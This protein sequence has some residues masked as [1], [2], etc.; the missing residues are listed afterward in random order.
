MYNS[1]YPNILPAQQVLQANGKASVDAIRMAPNSS[2]LVLDTTAPLVW[3][4]VTDGLGNVTATPY[5]ITP[6]V[7]TPPEDAL[8]KRLAAV[9]E[10]LKEVLYGKPDDGGADAE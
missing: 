3:L 6:H 9:E 10:K 8:E 5:E 4:C 1:F 7:E 2:V